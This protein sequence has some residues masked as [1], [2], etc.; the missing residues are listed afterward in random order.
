MLC[1]LADCTYVPAVES[2]RETVLLVKLSCSKSETCVKTALPYNAAVCV[3][4]VKTGVNGPRSQM[5]AVVRYSNFPVMM[6]YLAADVLRVMV[7]AD[8]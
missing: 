7:L 8:H 6:G 3:F 5:N 4:P 2:T 1:H